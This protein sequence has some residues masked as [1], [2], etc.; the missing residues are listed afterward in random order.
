[1]QTKTTEPNRLDIVDDCRLMIDFALSHGKTI[2]PDLIKRIAT[3][4]RQLAL[5]EGTSLL[6]K[7]GVLHRDLPPSAAPANAPVNSSGAASPSEEATVALLLEVHSQLSGVI[8]PASARSLRATHSER[9][10]WLSRRM[11]VPSIVQAAII[12]AIVCLVGFILTLPK[13][14]SSSTEPI[15]TVDT[16]NSR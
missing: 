15:S 13:P 1:M 8:A 12:L 4:D 11:D 9:T 6:G 2:E 16:P 3:L 7:A 10:N 14:S 5:A